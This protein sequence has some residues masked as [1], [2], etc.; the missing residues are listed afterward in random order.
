MV[1]A[2]VEYGMNDVTRRA[3]R[4]EEESWFEVGRT[5]DELYRNSEWHDLVDGY[6]DLVMF[7]KKQGSFGGV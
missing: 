2:L 3:I 1:I 6:Y 4:P 7:T 5:L